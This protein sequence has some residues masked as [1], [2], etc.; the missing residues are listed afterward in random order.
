M[1]L[2]VTLI[3]I[4][5]TSLALADSGGSVS[6]RV[7]WV[8]VPFQSLTIA[9]QHDGGDGVSDHFTLPPPTQADLARGCVE[10]DAALVL[11]ATSN[12]PWTV[13]VHA[14][15]TDMGASTDGSTR[16]PLSDFLLRVGDGA[17]LALSPFD[18]TLASGSAGST[19]LSVDYRVNV[20]PQTYVKGDYGVTLIYTITGS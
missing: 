4:L 9:G 5:S 16:K 14:I 18:Q 15:E 8:I 12:V 7:T 10:R 1:L 6:A 3:F 19:L 13:K 17:Y 11:Q 20:D 2:I